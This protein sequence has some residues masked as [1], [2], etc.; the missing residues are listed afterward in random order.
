MKYHFGWKFQDLK[1][2]FNPSG[3]MNHKVVTGLASM[4]ND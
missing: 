4:S 1:G 3:R 2:G